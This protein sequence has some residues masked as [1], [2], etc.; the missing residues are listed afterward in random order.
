MNNEI[1]PK[2]LVVLGATGS[3]GQSTLALARSYPERFKI[4]AITANKSAAQL[5]SYRPLSWKI[6]PY[7]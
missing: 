5:W 1:Q 6:G 7:G 4:T 2:K 3:I